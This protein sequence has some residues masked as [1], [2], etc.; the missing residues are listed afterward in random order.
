[1]RTREIPQRQ[2]LAVA[3]PRDG[4]AAAEQGFT[5][6]ELL[7][8]VVIMGLAIVAVL[9]GLLTLVSASGL[10]RQ[11]ADV[12]GVVESA[13]EIIKSDAYIPCAGSPGVP[14]Y[15]FQPPTT[16]NDVQTSSGSLSITYW[17]A[18]SQQFLTSLPT[19]PPQ[20]SAAPTDQGLQKIQV[21]F[22]STGSNPVTQ[23]IT[24][25]KGNP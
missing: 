12:G 19:C 21:S 8:A 9:G 25:V 11:Q 7:L 17:D 16:P 18:T 23:T 1:M 2:Q 22:S 20:S 24:L 6:I 3:L 10:H 15:S 13:A 5:L 14:F 4:L